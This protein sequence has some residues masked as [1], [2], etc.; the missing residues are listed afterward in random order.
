MERYGSHL[1]ANIGLVG[2]MVERQLLPRITAMAR[3][4]TLI[5]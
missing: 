3:W 2:G 4:R 5:R 1:T